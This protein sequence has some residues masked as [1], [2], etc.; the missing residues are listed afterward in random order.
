QPGVGEVPRQLLERGPKLLSVHRLCVSSAGVQPPWLPNLQR[1]TAD[2][3]V[4]SENEVESELRR[5]GS[6]SLSR[7]VDSG[8]RMSKRTMNE[9]HDCQGCAVAATAEMLMQKWTPLIVHDLS[10]GPR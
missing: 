10:E 6:S 3:P 7:G 8:G 1:G 2:P 4:T 9:V 5:G